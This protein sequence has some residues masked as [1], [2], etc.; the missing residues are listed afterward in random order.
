MDVRKLIE[1]VL[2]EKPEIDNFCDVQFELAVKK[3]IN[4]PSEE[5]IYQVLQEMG[6]K[7]YTPELEKNLPL[8]MP[9]RASEILGSMLVNELKNFYELA[10]KTKAQVQ[11]IETAER[12]YIWW[13]KAGKKEYII[14]PLQSKEEFKI[15]PLAAKIG[16]GPKIFEINLESLVEE[17]IAGPCFGDFD[18]KPEKLGECLG[19][20]YGL[21][22]KEGILYGDRIIDHLFFPPRRKP[23][24]IDYGSSEFGKNFSFDSDMAH[25]HLKSDAA[26]VSFANVYASIMAGL[27]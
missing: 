8:L 13:C 3:G 26:K 20:I 2:R 24:L 4:G 25:M 16:V 23:V 17:F 27:I 18:M 10:K 7:L 19:R 21:L 6:F 9:R 22:H 12:G 14:K 1:K 5:V 11:L 15:A